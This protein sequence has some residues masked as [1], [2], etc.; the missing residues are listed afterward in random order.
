LLLLAAVG[1]D[2]AGLGPPRSWAFWQAVAVV[3][4]EVLTVTMA[5]VVGARTSGRPGE[6]AP[7]RQPG[8]LAR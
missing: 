2:T 4:C 7:S 6:P 5:V 8:P 1:L 3:L